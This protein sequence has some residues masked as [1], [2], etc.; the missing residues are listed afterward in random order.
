MKLCIMMKFGFIALALLCD[1]FYG[2]ARWTCAVVVYAL[3]CSHCVHIVENRL[4]LNSA[5]PAIKQSL[6]IASHLRSAFTVQAKMRAHTP[7]AQSAENKAWRTIHTN[8]GTK[9]NF[10][11]PGISGPASNAT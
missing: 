2:I 3:V 9:N 11:N 7:S 1:L 5:E 8:I 4:Q 10:N 6:L